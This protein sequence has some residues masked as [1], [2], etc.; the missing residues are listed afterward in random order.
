MQ[1]LPD[2]LLYTCNYCTIT[3]VNTESSDRAFCRQDQFTVIEPFTV[4][5]RKHKHWQSFTSITASIRV[6]LNM[7]VDWDFFVRDESAALDRCHTCD[8]LARFCR[9]SVQQSSAIKLHAL[10][11]SSCTLSHKR[12]LLYTSP[13]PRDS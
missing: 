13:S 6:V 9:A 8:F 12:C 10:Q 3:C 4:L 11:L 2:D 5:Q 1:R 7:E